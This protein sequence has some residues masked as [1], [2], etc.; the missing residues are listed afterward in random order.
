MSITLG[1]YLSKDFCVQLSQQ[2]G[3]LCT[4][5]VLFGSHPCK[6]HTDAFTSAYACR[7]QAHQVWVSFDP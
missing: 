4:I 3:A 5:I 7:C 2:F 1:Y 6:L